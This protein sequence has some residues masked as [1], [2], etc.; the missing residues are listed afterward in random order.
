MI[1]SFYFCKSIF[2]FKFVNAFFVPFPNDRSRLGVAGAINSSF[3]EAELM[4][5]FELLRK[6]S[7]STFFFTD[8]SSDFIGLDSFDSEHATLAFFCFGCTCVVASCVVGLTTS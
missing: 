4:T 5:D 1:T 6:F 3:D 2:C 7:G 8:L